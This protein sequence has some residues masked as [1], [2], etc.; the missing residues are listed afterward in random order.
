MA[1]KFVLNAASLRALKREAHREIDNAIQERARFQGLGSG[2]ID[3]G[4][5]HSIEEVE[6]QTGNLV[7]AAD[8]LGAVLIAR[9]L[10]DPDDPET[11]RS[12]GML[13]IG[14]TEGALEWLAHVR[15]G[16]VEHLDELDEGNEASYD[17][18]TKEAYL[19]HVLNRMFAKVEVA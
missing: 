3:G 14:L 12:E 18:S 1:S 6:K 8:V 16:V 13:E 9:D 17:V 2:P 7:A 5:P 4:S 15:E 19:A 11:E 10:V